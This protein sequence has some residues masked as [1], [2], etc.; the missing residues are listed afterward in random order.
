MR[1]IDWTDKHELIQADPEFVYSYKD[2]MLYCGV[3]PCEHC[4]FRPGITS[5]QKLDYL[6][7]LKQ[8]HLMPQWFL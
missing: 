5:C 2:G 3:L 1:V 7:W 8:N 6:V 4:I